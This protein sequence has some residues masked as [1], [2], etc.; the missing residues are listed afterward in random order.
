MMATLGGDN[1][2][3]GN[4]HNNKIL[5]ITKIMNHFI[6]REC[7]S[8]KLSKTKVTPTLSAVVL[9]LLLFIGGSIFFC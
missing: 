8:A 1:S 4:A 5:V 6:I 7:N 9:K 3:G 2:G